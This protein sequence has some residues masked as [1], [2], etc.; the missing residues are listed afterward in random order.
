[1]QKEISH[2][3]KIP[4]FL[5][6]TK[7]DGKG[8]YMKFQSKNKRLTFEFYFDVVPPC[9]EDTLFSPVGLGLLLDLQKDL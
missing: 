4:M 5:M 8:T 3:R 6:E 2:E 7:Y 9:L 1:M